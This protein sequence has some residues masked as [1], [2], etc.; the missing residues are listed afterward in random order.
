MSLP[1]LKKNIT[2][3]SIRRYAEASGDFNPIHLD[4]EFA[5]NTPAGGIIAH[6][7]L[8]LAFVS[9]MMTQAFGEE[10]IKTGKLDV[11]FKN[12]ARPGDTITITGK[13]KREIPDEKGKLIV[14]EIVC[15]NQK[16]EAIIT[17]DA[18]VRISE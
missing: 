9:Q 11:R 2:R 15:I 6:G 16:N 4:E 12:P 13:V 10:W 7:M 18:T 3:E 5:K 8:S 14:H 17:G 1:E